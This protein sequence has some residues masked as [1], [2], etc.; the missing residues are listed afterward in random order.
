M[1]QEGKF[2]IGCDPEFFLYDRDFEQYMSA[3][4][5]VKGTKE[6]PEPL[7][8]GGFIMR[9]NV[10][11]EFGMPPANSI[12][13]WVE[14]VNLTM[15]DVERYIPEWLE[16]KVVAS[17]EFSKQQLTDPEAKEIGCDP[18][19]NAWTGKRNI[20][21]IG[22]AESTFR[23]CGG[24]IHVGYVKE[25]G[26]EFLLDNDGKRY[27]IQAMDCVHGLWSVL[28]D[29]SP[30]SIA[31]RNIYGKAGC[32]RPTEY[33][34]EYRTLSNFWVKTNKLKELMYRFTADALALAS[35]IAQLNH[36][37]RE[38]GGADKVQGIINTGDVDWIKDSFAMIAQYISPETDYLL[39]EVL[40]EQD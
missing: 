6:K 31:R 17:G 35:D 24:H 34:V 25:S 5:F 7:N 21:P 1:E 38:I 28:L 4:P 32:Y 37:I 39:V 8:S 2:T 18:D 15:R 13:E 12:D 40:N 16:L 11:L 22:F 23:S 36:V 26:N 27:M 10:A 30:E 29:N 3:I 19:F 14:S 20:P 33:G 9:D